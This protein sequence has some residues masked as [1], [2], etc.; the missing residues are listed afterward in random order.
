MAT[1]SKKTR[2][3]IWSRD[4]GLCVNCKKRAQEIHHL[5]ANTKTNILVYT[6]KLIQSAINGV[7]VCKDCHNKY[8]TWDKELVAKVRKL[9]EQFSKS[10][11]KDKKTKPKI[12]CIC[13]STRFL[14]THAIKRWEFEKQGIICLTINFLPLD[15]FKESAHGAEQDGVKEILDELHLRKID[16]A[17]EVYIIN[18]GG[19]IGES[20][21]NEINYAEIL[22]K[23]IIY[24]E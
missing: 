12:I 4:G 8:S 13:G 21:R 7:C 20:T 3:E 6:N 2:E 15:Y 16:L 10:K 17:D 9:F 11:M 1:F 23:K 19:Y 14:S 22:G 18:A 24:M 5:I